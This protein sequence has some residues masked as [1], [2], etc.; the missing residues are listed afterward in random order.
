M[1]EWYKMIE[2]VIAGES[3]LCKKRRKQGISKEQFAHEVVEMLNGIVNVQ[4]KGYR[5]FKAKVVKK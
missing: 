2:E 1:E 4:Y 5:Q 3:E